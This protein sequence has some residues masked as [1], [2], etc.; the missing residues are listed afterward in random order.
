MLVLTSY[1]SEVR[2]HLEG[3]NV[4]VIM[5]TCTAPL[6][7]STRGGGGTDADV[8][9]L[10]VCT[11][12]ARSLHVRQDGCVCVREKSICRRQRRET[13]EKTWR[14]HFCCT[15]E[16]GIPGPVFPSAPIQKWAAAE[17][18]QAVWRL[19][20]GRPAVDT[21]D[22]SF[23]KNLYDHEAAERSTVGGSK[24]KLQPEH[25]NMSKNNYHENFDLMIL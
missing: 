16:G 24:A 17:K 1:Y 22:R 9:L 21:D 13:M 11:Y 12:G 6:W 8:G 2:Q 25:A 18:L 5:L 20:Q 19:H 10:C 14:G 23:F 7:L 4:T 15:A 3:G